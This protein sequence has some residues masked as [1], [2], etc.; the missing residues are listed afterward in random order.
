MTTFHIKGSK[1]TDLFTNVNA[2]NSH[3]FKEKLDKCLQK[4]N[5]A[6]A[7]RYT[8]H[9]RLRK[10]PKRLEVKGNWEK[11]YSHSP[12]S[13]LP[14]TST[15][16]RQNMR[17]M[18]PYSKQ[19]SCSVQGF[20]ALLA[21][22]FIKVQFDLSTTAIKTNVQFSSKQLFFDTPIKVQKIEESHQHQCFQLYT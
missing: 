17:L 3:K 19:L 8:D 13:A 6:Y 12:C 22:L 1:F 11:R 9:K 4:G 7:V 21:I 18:G 2:K 14:Q 15:G 5:P 16:G 10:S 20:G